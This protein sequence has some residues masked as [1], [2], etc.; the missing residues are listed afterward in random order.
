MKI[1]DVY[2]RITNLWWRKNQLLE[3]FN[4]HV[5][6]DGPDQ[7]VFDLINKWS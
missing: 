3:L 6:Y 1:A 2:N 7:S 4:D 5:C